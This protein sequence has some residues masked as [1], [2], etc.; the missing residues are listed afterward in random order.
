MQESTKPAAVAQAATLAVRPIEVKAKTP[1]EAPKTVIPLLTLFRHCDILSLDLGP[2][3]VD[4]IITDPPYGIDMAMLN[5]NNPHGG[6][7]DIDRVEATHQVD[8]NL[9]LLHAFI[10][11][12]YDWIKPGGFFAFFYD[13]MHHNFLF[14][15]C[16]EVGFKVQ[17]WP[18]RWEK[19][20]QCMNQ[21]AQ[22]NFTKDF[23]PVMICRKGNATLAKPATSSRIL[24]SNDAKTT[25]HPFAKPA[26]VWQTLAEHMTHPNQLILDPFAGS[27]SSLK[28]FITMRRQIIGCEI[29]EKHFNT[30]LI[31]LKETY[32]RTYA[33]VE[34]V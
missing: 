4:H 24:A 20:H 3:S 28:M 9:K 23:E 32:Q 27:C 29:D 11:R 14:N 8:D 33:N 25:S 16:E 7:V 19:T 10:G 26:L 22:Y 12:A 17:R 18:V 21:S 30:G 1:T 31:E 13:I 34:F 2:M 15:R 5:Q 6:M